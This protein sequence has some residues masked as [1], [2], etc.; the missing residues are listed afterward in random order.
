MAFCKYCGSQLPEDSV[1]C[2]S[3]GKNLKS[4]NETSNQAEEN[5][6]AA[7]ETQKEEEKASG[8]TPT[9][10]NSK[11]GDIV[12]LC[13]PFDANRPMTVGK[14]YEIVKEAHSVNGEMMVTVK[15]PLLEKYPELAKELEEKAEMFSCEYPHETVAQATHTDKKAGKKM[16]VGFIALCVVV[17]AVVLCFKLDLLGPK[18]VEGIYTNQYGVSLQFDKNG[19]VWISNLKD[20]TW[21]YNGFYEI[22]GDTLILHPNKYNR[23]FVEKYKIEKDTLTGFYPDSFKEFKYTKVKE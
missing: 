4:T 22:D 8:V 21:D 19:D 18:K 23:S 9:V 5:D 15:G 16:I 13:K 20:Y 6:S 17:F 3:C 2:S 1:F 14:K 10:Q 7:F 12:Y 11:V